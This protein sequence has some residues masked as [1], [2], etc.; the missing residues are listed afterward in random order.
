MLDLVIRGARIVDGTGAPAFTGDVGVR[1]GRIVAV[2][3]VDEPATRTID[4]DGLA[5]APGFIDIHTHYDVQ[6]LWDPALTPSP[7]HGVTTVI[8]GNC[9]FSIAPL[10]PEHVELRQG[11]DGAGRGHA[12]GV[13][14]RRAGVGLAHVRRVARPHRRSP[15]RSTP[16]SSWATRPCAAW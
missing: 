7:L 13:A 14:R 16:A 12:A 10:E 6:A 11:D 15:V 4:A 3:A 2:G 9:G 1:D 8:G 5:V